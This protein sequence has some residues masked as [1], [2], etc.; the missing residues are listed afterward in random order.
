MRE[1]RG[2]YDFIE[3]AVASHCPVWKEGTMALLCG[4]DK[5]LIPYA[6][7]AFRRLGYSEEVTVCL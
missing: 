4:S 2:K 3:R 5:L 1:S 7:K 6:L